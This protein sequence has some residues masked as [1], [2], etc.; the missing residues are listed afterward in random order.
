MK[1]QIFYHRAYKKLARTR[2]SNLLKFLIL[3]IPIDLVIAVFYFR[4]M[5]SFVGVV[6]EIL[7]RCGVYTQIETWPFLP[8]VFR[9][10][11]LLDM[12]VVYPS[13]Q[14]ALINFGVSVLVVALLPRL[15]I[16]PR[17]LMVWVV[18]VA[19]INTV[20]SAFFTLIPELFPYDIVLFS[21]LYMGTQLGMWLLIPLILAIALTPL[22]AHILEKLSIVVLTVIYSIA[23]GAVRYAAFLYVMYKSSVLYMAAMFFTFGPLFDFVYVVGIYSIYVSVMANRLQRHQEIWRWLF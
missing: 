1:D 16:I 8:Y 9:D 17:P 7:L 11:Y 3:V 22:P 12:A 4:L 13:R 20:S 6:R 10:V 15:R 18:F 2:L 23:F 19:L 21:S 14:F 5:R